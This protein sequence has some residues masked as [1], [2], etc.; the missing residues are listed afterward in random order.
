M[1]QRIRVLVAEDQPL[2]RTSLSCLLRTKPD[3]EVIGEA[4]NGA[5]AVEMAN[6]L[7][8]DVVVMDYGMPEMTG[9]D[10]TRQITADAPGVRVV[11]LSWRDDHAATRAML[12]A[13]AAAYIE[14]S[15]DMAPLLDAIRQ[16]AAK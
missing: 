10:A 8:P 5:I 15:G 4:E 2:V 6:R 3:L 7:R 1:E 14:K 16:A 13:G 9:A 11:G 12:D